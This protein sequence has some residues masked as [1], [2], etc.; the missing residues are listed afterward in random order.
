MSIVINLPDGSATD[1]VDVAVKAFEQWLVERNKPE[2]STTPGHVVEVWE[3]GEITI[4]KSGDLYG[5]RG[6]HQMMPPH[7]LFREVKMN[8]PIKEHSHSRVCVTL[9]EG[10]EFQKL[11]W[12]F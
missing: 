6:L 12:G 3:D 11:L 1:Q 4:T 10:D 9:G 8:L 2:L 7:R 5:Q